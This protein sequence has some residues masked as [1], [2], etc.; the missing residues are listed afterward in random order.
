MI[1]KKYLLLFLCVIM[2]VTNVLRVRANDWALPGL[3]IDSSDAA[4]DGNGSAGSGN[5]SGNGTGNNNSPWYNRR[6]NNKKIM[7]R[8]T[9]GYKSRLNYQPLVSNPNGT[10]IKSGTWIGVNIQEIQTASWSVSNFEFKEIKKKYH[11]EKRIPG[12]IT[13]SCY[14]TLGK[15]ICPGSPS[16]SQAYGCR[17]GSDRIET[18]RHEEKDYYESFS[19]PAGY[20]IKSTEKETTVDESIVQVFKNAIYKSAHDTAYGMVGAPL[21]KLQIITD[22]LDTNNNYKTLILDGIEVESHDTG[23]AASGTIIKKYEYKPNNICINLKTGKVSYNKRCQT[24]EEVQVLPHYSNGIRYWQ[25]FSPLS[26]KSGSNLS[27]VVLSGRQLNDKECQNGKSKYGSNYINSSCKVSKTYNLN[28]VQKYYYEETKNNKLVFN[29]YNLYYRPIN[30]NNPFPTIPTENSL[31]YKWYNSKDK[32]PNLKDSF[33][34]VTYSVDVPN[35]LADTIR[36][37]NVNNPYPSFDKLSLSGTSDFLRSVGVEALTKDKK[38]GLG[39]GTRTCV[40]NGTVS[41]GSDCS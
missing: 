23:V 29:G 25:Y 6:Y 21:S 40:K 9:V 31:W 8:Y 19:C 38:Y 15:V 18:I 11:C 20:E 32:S 7:F 16:Y 35:K 41:I 27:L 12:K 33:N 39:G 26:M 13:C 1:K 24:D 30:I 3:D 28:V 2:L 17:R 36:A 34:E 5:G 37:Y 14:Y 22:E 4:S 10:I